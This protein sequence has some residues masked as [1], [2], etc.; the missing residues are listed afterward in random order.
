MHTLTHTHAHTYTHTHTRTSTLPLTI[1]VLGNGA[2]LAHKQLAILLRG[3]LLWMLVGSRAARLGERSCHNLFF[4]GGQ[5]EFVGAQLF[6]SREK[7]G[8]AMGSDA[9]VCRERVFINIE[10]IVP[11]EARVVKQQTEI[12]KPSVLEPLQTVCHRP[13]PR[14]SRRGLAHVAPD[15]STCCSD[16]PLALCRVATILPRW[17]CLITKK[18]HTTTK[19]GK[20]GRIFKIH[21]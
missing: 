3:S 7:R 5:H 1:A 12:L 18:K 17:F 4:F 2:G 20:S 16:A 14:P 15:S 6:D 10:Q 21:T 9:A 11:T 13:V 8:N 19:K